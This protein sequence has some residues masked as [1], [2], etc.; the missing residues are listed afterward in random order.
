MTAVSIAT[1]YVRKDPFL[2]GGI[3]WKLG[4]YFILGASTSFVNSYLLEMDSSYDNLVLYLQ[5]S[6]RQLSEQRSR[7]RHIVDLYSISDEIW[8]REVCLC[9]HVHVN[10]ITQKQNYMDI[11]N[12][13]YGFVTRLVDPYQILNQIHPKVYM[14]IRMHV[15]A[16]TLN[17]K[18]PDK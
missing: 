10:T 18:K 9:V 5:P 3:R 11:L 4:F 15:N 17:C 14:S 13:T 1:G 6:T 7:G 16:I 8:Q 12:L 2:I